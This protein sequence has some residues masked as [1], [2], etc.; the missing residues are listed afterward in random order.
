MQAGSKEG[1]LQALCYLLISNDR[2]NDV[3]MTSR[4]SNLRLVHLLGE[5][6]NAIALPLGRACCRRVGGRADRHKTDF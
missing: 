5:T 3:D 4:I 1:L 2:C 6:Q